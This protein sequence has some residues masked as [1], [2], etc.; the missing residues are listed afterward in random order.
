[1]VIRPR[2]HLMKQTNAIRPSHKTVIQPQSLN[3]FLVKCVQ[4]K[5]FFYWS[6]L[7]S[8]QTIWFCNNLKCHRNELV[9]FNQTNVYHDQIARNN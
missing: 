5:P 2:V 7:W 3:V 4:K 6:C 1:M 9:L 8:G